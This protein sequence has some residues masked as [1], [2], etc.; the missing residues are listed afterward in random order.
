[1]KESERTEQAALAG[2]RFKA[3]YGLKPRACGFRLPGVCPLETSEFRRYMPLPQRG[4]MADQIVIPVA[5]REMP[6][7]SFTLSMRLQNILGWKE[8]RM[9]G[10][11]NGLRFSEVARWRNCGKAT[12]LELLGIVRCLQH[13]KW[14]GRISRNPAGNAD[15]YEI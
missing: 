2:C 1:M 7:S 9:L 4:C 8:C 12:L 11:L 3:P 10:D 13:G 5:V 14:V 6:I 15:T